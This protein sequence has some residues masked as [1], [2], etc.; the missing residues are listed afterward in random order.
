MISLAG[1]NP[2]QWWLA[3]DPLDQAFIVGAAQRA[4]VVRQLEWEQQAVL[5][6]NKVGEMLGV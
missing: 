5:I 1:M 3:T 6:A 2:M 4:H